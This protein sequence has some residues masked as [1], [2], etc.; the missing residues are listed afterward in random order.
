MASLED[1]E[2]LEHELQERKKDDDKKKDEEG[3][4]SNKDK[5]D[6]DGEDKKDEDEID[7]DILS[8]ATADIINRRRLMENDLRVMRQDFQRLTHEKSSMK[9]KIKDNLEKIENNR[10]AARGKLEASAPKLTIAPQT[11]SLPGWK[12]R[13]AS[14]PRSHRRGGGW[15]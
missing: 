13:R 10:Y 2:D 6:V 4:D 8:A 9:E 11:A 15:R 14:R 1:L 5:M 12:C 3:G 7:P